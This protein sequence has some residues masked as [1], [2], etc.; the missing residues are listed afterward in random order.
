MNQKIYSSQV[1]HEKHPNENKFSP[2]KFMEKWGELLQAK[3]PLRKILITTFS[4]IILKL[5]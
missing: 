2:D 4:T 1:W 5:N 3:E